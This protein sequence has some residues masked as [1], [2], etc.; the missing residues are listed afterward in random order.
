MVDPY[1]TFKA[2]SMVWPKQ[3]T[4]F[5]VI[6][7]LLDL[8][9][10]QALFYSFSGDGRV[11]LPHPPVSVLGICSGMAPYQLTPGFHFPAGDAS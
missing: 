3:C 11:G 2:V 8:S 4:G 6:M 7:I 1:G 5:F 9:I 10:T